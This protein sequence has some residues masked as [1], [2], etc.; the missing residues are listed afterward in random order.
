VRLGSS[1]SARMRVTASAAVSSLDCG[2]FES[3]LS[4]GS[5]VRQG[6]G[7]S[8]SLFTRAG[9]SVSVLDSYSTQATGVVSSGFSALDSVTLG[10]SLPF[11]ASSV[12][13]SS[14]SVVSVVNIGRRMS[15]LLDGVTIGSVRSCRGVSRLGSSLT[16]RSATRLGGETSVFDF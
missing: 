1:V 14:L 5:S 13:G 8:V 10:S 4:A 7:L 3:S 16:V 2:L 15:V 11:R 12:G 6:S 9:G